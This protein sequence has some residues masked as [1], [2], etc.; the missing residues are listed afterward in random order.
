MRKDPF[1]KVAQNSM[2][3][4][5]QLHI[6]GFEELS[7]EQVLNPE[8]LNSSYWTGSGFFIEVNGE[9]GH[10][11]TNAHVVRNSLRIR[12]KTMV[13]S[14][15]TFDVEVVGLVSSLNPDVAL[16]RLPDKEIRRF[17]RYHSSS[18]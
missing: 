3:S 18:S 2:L 6:E 9:P 12:L 15:E 5:V 16:L 17:E 11:L 14:N 1:I 7:H 13:T 10:I 4:V 8:F